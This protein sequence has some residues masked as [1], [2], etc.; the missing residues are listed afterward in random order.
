MLRMKVMK[1]QFVR[2]VKHLVLCAVMGLPLVSIG[3]LDTEFWFVAP[4]ISQEHGDTP[5]QFVIAAGGAPA[6]VTFSMPAEP[7]FSPITLSLR[8]DEVQSINVTAFKELL[9]N[10]PANQVLNK[11]ILISATEPITVYY[12]CANTFNQDI[13]ALKGRNGLGKVFFIP[14]QTDFANILGSSAFD[15]VATQDSTVIEITTSK[16]IIGRTA[17]APFTVVLNRG[18][19]YSARAIG[20]TPFNHLDGSVLRASK[21]VAVTNSDDSILNG[22]NTGWDLVGDQL[23][24]AD[25][26]GTEYI[27]VR[28]FAQTER[29]YV[30]ATEDNTTVE[31]FGNTPRQVSL[32]QG[33]S[34]SFDIQGSVIYVRS[35]AP[36]YVW[37]L[38]GILREP[39]GALL[40]A[41]GCSG[42][43]SIGFQRP[44][45]N[46][47]TMLLVTR[48]G[49]ENAFLMDGQP[50]FI[51]TGDFFDVPGT[52]GEWVAARLNVNARLSSG[53]HRMSNTEGN[54]QMGILSANGS[55]SS[56]GY[57]SSFNS[58]N[59]GEEAAFCE[60]ER[61][62]LDAG[63][64][65]NVYDWNTGANTQT[66][67]VDRPGTYS[68]RVA[69]QGCELA[70]TIAVEEIRVSPDLGAD[71]SLCAGDT[72]VLE[73]FQPGARYAWQDGSTQSSFEVTTA[74]QYSVSIQKDGCQGSASRRVDVIVPPDLSLG[75]DTTLC[76]GEALL[77]DLSSP[78]STHV[79]E[80]Q[81]TS[82]VRVLDTAG[83]FSVVR[84][85][86]GCPVED[87]L[88]IF[89]AQPAPG[90]PGDTLLCL[91]DTLVISLPVPSVRYQ[92]SDGET[93]ARRS[94]SE[95]GFYVLE[96]SNRCA[97][98]LDT[99]SISTEDCACQLF[100]PNVFTPNGD[101]FNDRFVP[102]ISC[103]WEAFEWRIFD[104]WGKQVFQSQVPFPGWDGRQGGTD[105][106]EGVY[107]YHIHYRGNARYNDG[108]GTRTGSFLLLR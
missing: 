33:R 103:D 14:T 38:S 34:A 102:E 53:F 28:G 24:P 80:D 87:S 73:A 19:T 54:F 85:F 46:Q 35:S 44:P 3:Q 30:L 2:Q 95:E 31:T 17:N 107:F 63:P 16:N 57:F 5:I 100:V 98:T 83:M 56:Y 89:A 41:I 9:E 68:V 29:I 22:V 4:E 72:L 43:Q 15:V 25:I 59:L 71:T 81:S 86:Q 58:L 7:S 49:Y 1:F 64:G 37:H 91:G 52:D 27:A 45:V 61:L 26:V 66:I 18:E 21:P 55:T 92:W 12:Q 48:S 40:P 11:G 108:P 23:V 97:S 36:V 96:A 39:G 70:D 74:G 79:W 104:R 60:G 47:V 94:F 6:R 105:L 50:G 13:F 67:T 90:L 76:E 75:P 65:K 20:Q 99:L 82:P 8:A 32:D 51:Q 93:L 106:Q 101:G 88:Q 62:V 84:E 69:F 42:S 77:I 78:G 10:K